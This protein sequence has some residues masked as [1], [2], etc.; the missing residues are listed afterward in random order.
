V[1]RASARVC[2][3]G[4][5]VAHG[6]R[7]PITHDVR[8]PVAGCGEVA[9]SDD[10]A[11]V[12]TPMPAAPTWRRTLLVMR[13]DAVEVRALPM[14]GEMVVGRGSACNVQVE[15]PS[16]SRTHLTL[17]LTEDAIRVRDQGGANGTFL[18]GARLPAGVAVDVTAN[19]ALTAGEVVLVVQ[20]VRA[21]GTPAE[22]AAARPSGAVSLS[23]AEPVVVDPAMKRLHELAA[24]VARGD[25]GVLITGETGAGKEVLAEAIHRASPRAAGPLVRI[26]CAALTESLVESELFGH[27]KGS[28]TGAVRDH[29]GLLEIAGGGTVFLDE[30][31]ELAPAIQAKLLRVVEERKVLAVG[32]TT[33]RA[34]D[35]RF[36]AATNRDL[37][38]DVA[39]GRFRGDLYFRL[40]GVVLTIPPLRARPAEIEV[41]ARRFAGTRAVSDDAIS[42]L[43]ARPWPGNVRELAHAIERAALLADGEITAAHLAIDPPPPAP[44]GDTLSSELAT[45]E[46]ERILDALDQHGGN[47]TRAAA[48]LGMP[49]RTFVKRLGQYGVARPRKR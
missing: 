36:V 46:R 18:R 12:P 2:P 20:E 4:G 48:S 49:L 45:L 31:G 47:Q 7:D 6:V 42:A 39:A 33:P 43:R 34:I 35:V 25:I 27:E 24:R 11:T 30:I 40:A 3:L 13:G 14:R 17:L 8:D 28:F 15:H 32:A 16:M 41:L 38:A 44:A 23:A 10:I 5:A 37:E 22:P 21:T 1:P 9:D 19:E 29:R 26:N